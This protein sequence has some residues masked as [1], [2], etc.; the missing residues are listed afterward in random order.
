[1][2]ET[3]WYQSFHYQ[4]WFCQLFLRASH[5][6]TI[7]CHQPCN[8][9]WWTYMIPFFGFSLGGDFIF[10]N[11]HPYLG[12][13][14]ILTNVFQMGWNHQLAIVLIF[15]ALVFEWMKYLGISNRFF[16]TAN[17]VYLYNHAFQRLIFERNEWKVYSSCTCIPWKIFSI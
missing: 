14:P 7:W 1:M 10:K 15:K 12:K 3:F 9:Y 2:N 6:K 13:I 11:F 16:L 4:G 5:V 8:R 17:M